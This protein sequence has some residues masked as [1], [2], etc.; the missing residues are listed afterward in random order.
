MR[1]LT[2]VLIT[3][4]T[5]TAHADIADAIKAA[6]AAEIRT[7]AERA[8]DKN[9]LPVETLQFF[10]LTQDMRVLELLPGGGW[11]TKL[12]APVLREEGQLYLAVGTDRVRDNLLKEPG[13]DRVEV[14]PV[15]TEF[16]RE[17]RRNHHRRSEFG[18]K[19]YRPGAHLPQPAQPHGNRAKDDERGRVQGAEAW[20]QLRGRRSHSPTHA[21]RLG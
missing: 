3:V 8:R 1:A 13:F 19:T 20:R 11:Y 5:A 12:L 6:Q 15:D 21:S 17:G 16:K 9:R 7:D 2:C 4:L 18:R 14:V 10:G